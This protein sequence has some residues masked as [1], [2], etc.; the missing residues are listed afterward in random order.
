M[1]NDNIQTQNQ[2]VQPEVRPSV[3]FPETPRKKSGGFPKWIIAVVGV[4]LILAV[5]GFFISRSLGS[6]EETEPT[7]TPAG[8][9]SLPTPNVTSTPTP[10]AVEEV[11]K[12]EVSIEVLNGTGTAGEATFLQGELEDLGYE[13]IEVGNATSQNETETTVT[14]SNDMPDEIVDE[15]TEALED[16]YD[17]VTVSRGTVSGGFDIRILT[18]PRA[19]ASPRA[20]ATASPR[21]S[22][23]ASPTPTASPSN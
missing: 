22:A 3:G 4:L 10:E 5:G 16:I 2:P 20:S 17:E 9:S 19:G 7:T 8:L 15:L 13:E 23:T 18:G 1:E 12:S 21:A 14:I 6:S 11:D